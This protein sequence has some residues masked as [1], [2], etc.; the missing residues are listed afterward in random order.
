MKDIVNT[1]V[2]RFLREKRRRNRQI[3][4]L[5]ALAALVVFGV[6]WSLHYTG[7]A[8][9]NEASCGQEEHTHTS[10]CYEEQLVLTCGQEESD[11]HTHNDSRYSTETVLI[12]GHEEHVHTAACYASDSDEDAKDEGTDGEGSSDSTG[13]SSS[14]SA[15]GTGDTADA[16][17]GESSGDDS[18]D[19]A[20]NSTGSESAD[21]DGESVESAD[22]GNAEVNAASEM[23]QNA[24]TAGETGSNGNA[25][26]SLTSDNESALGSSSLSYVFGRSITIE[27]DEF[28]GTNV[29]ILTLSVTDKNY[30]EDEYEYYSYLTGETLELT[31]D[32]SGGQPGNYTY[33]IY[34][35]L[36]DLA[37]LYDKLFTEQDSLLYGESLK[38][39]VSFTLNTNN[40]VTLG[41]YSS[42]LYWD[43]SVGTYGAY[44]VEFPVTQ[45]DTAS[46]TLKVTYP[47]KYTPGGDLAIYG[48]I[49]NTASGGI[50]SASGEAFLASWTTDRH[51]F[52]VSIE[53]TSQQP[54]GLTMSADE[55]G[56]IYVAVTNNPDQ[57]IIWNIS[58]TNSDGSSEYKNIG[59]DLITGISVTDIIELPTGITWTG[60][61]SDINVDVG[62]NGYITFS[63]GSG[64]ELLTL[65]NESNNT[66][67]ENS[68]TF[69]YD[70][71]SN[72]LTITWEILN[73]NTSGNFATSEID[74]GDWQVQ[75]NGK[76]LTYSDP[77]GSDFENAKDSHTITNTVIYDYHYTW[78]KD[79]ES[80]AET[81]I[82][83][84]VT[85]GNVVLTKTADR[86]GESVF[87][88]EDAYYTISLYNQS[89]QATTDLSALNDSALSKEQYISPENI[90]KMFFP[91]TTVEADP[92]SSSYDKYLATDSGDYLTITITDAC[93]YYD[94]LQELE[95]MTD[96]GGNEGTVYKTESNYLITD[97]PAHYCS[98]DN[99]GATIKITKVK[100]EDGSKEILVEFWDDDIENE[101]LADSATMFYSFS[102]YDAEDLELKLNEMGYVVTNSA[103]YSAVWDLTGHQLNGGETRHYKVYSSLKNT[104]QYYENL[105]LNV[106]SAYN[107]ADNIVYLEYTDEKKDESATAEYTKISIDFRLTKSIKQVNGEDVSAGDTVDYFYDNSIIQYNIKVDHIGNGEAEDMIVNDVLYGQYLLV[108]WNAANKAS[109][110]AGKWPGYGSTD[111]YD[112]RTLMIDGEEYV[113]LMFSGHY[114]DVWI[115][116]THCLSEAMVDFTGEYV[117]DG[118]Y[119]LSD[120]CTVITYCYDDQLNGTAAGN[121]NYL[122]LIY[123]N[124]SGYKM[125]ASN[126]VYLNRYIQVSNYYYWDADGY[127]RFYSALY[128]EIDSAP[129]ISGNLSKKILTSEK[130]ATAENE[131]YSTSS[132]IDLNA[133]NDYSQ[134]VRYK[135]EL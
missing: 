82:E 48:V 79:G 67:D 127:S 68:F 7:I 108:P 24:L 89:T 124:N 129:I 134:S 49:Y 104:F 128:D 120:I 18:T 20:G 99:A 59:E 113:P 47:S 1:Y 118:G 58:M 15:E 14:G 62:S 71:D 92:T 9:A 84:S 115:D 61:M 97:T 103:T 122:T 70:S 38:T 23:E 112:E 57:P 96:I 69:T 130:E 135:L 90:W 91:E 2:N 46:G 75:L 76:Y 74:N 133:T 36:M 77:Y 6:S 83:I 32:I 28:A 34:F 88:G 81:T 125:R 123:Y 106:A 65:I 114:Y 116:D 63:D 37:G 54:N 72:E 78:S 22:S 45:N 110:R 40:V 12:C 10:E 93:V 33:R 44:Y 66:V 80:T 119:Y 121:L 60:D 56:N 105:Y 13:G 107:T 11:E 86:S 87:M 85:D 19:D 132:Q 55:D 50:V 27:P 102:T 41:D 16:N 30:A 5:L 100:T 31:F 43:G 26:I 131:T 53:N 95:T 39:Q 4:T 21:S 17:G 52:D 64:N 98:T 111:W 117:A 35:E 29:A 51:E 101:S 109:V 3:C 73:F 42:E 25:G 94:K 8:L 126:A